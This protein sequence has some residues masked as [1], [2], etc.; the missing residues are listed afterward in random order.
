MNETVTISYGSFCVCTSAQP[1]RLALVC[2]IRHLAT[3]TPSRLYSPKRSPSQAPV[4]HTL[5][6]CVSPHQAPRRAPPAAPS[7]GSSALTLSAVVGRTL[8]R[9]SASS[10]SSPS[11]SLSSSRRP[12]SHY[13]SAPLSNLHRTSH[14]LPDSK[15]RRPTASPHPGAAPHA[16]NASS[17]SSSTLRPHRSLSVPC[18]GPITIRS[19]I[20]ASV[21][22][23]AM[24][25]PPPESDSGSDMLAAPVTPPAAPMT[26]S[27][28]PPP[29]H[30]VHCACP[31][32]GEGA[33]SLLL[34]TVDFAAWV[35]GQ[36]A[37][38]THTG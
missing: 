23:T 17:S 4:T 24:N 36:C 31:H 19:S 14:S 30:G 15:P 22:V 11:S 34:R 10:S 7:S 6:T 13:S 1:R 38:E 26:P 8:R 20:S 18:Y 5:S 33:L 2:P 16:S 9:L 35:S 29:A 37:G 12:F 21:T 32:D 28:I 3:P 25:T 27:P